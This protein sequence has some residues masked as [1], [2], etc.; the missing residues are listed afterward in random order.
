[1]QD[2]NWLLPSMQERTEEPARNTFNSK[3]GEQ[4]LFMINFF[5]RSVG[6]NIV[7]DSN[8]SEL[9]LLII[10]MP[11][12]L[13]SEKSVFNYLRGRYLYRAV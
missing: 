5:A 11:V 13:K 8:I 4:V 7:N 10:E 6:A 3:N 1:M 9:E 12:N 2:Y